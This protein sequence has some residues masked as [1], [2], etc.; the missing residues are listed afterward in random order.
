MEKLFI[1]LVCMIAFMCI[2]MVFFAI[3]KWAE[4]EK[5]KT[6]PKFIESRYEMD[7]YRKLAPESCEEGMHSDNTC[8]IIGLLIKQEKQLDVMQ[9]QIL[10]LQNGN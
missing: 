5:H 6:T 3:P 10:E 9:K 1:L 4:D 7:Q 2:F 8:E